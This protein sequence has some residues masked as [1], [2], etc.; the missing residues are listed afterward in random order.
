MNPPNFLPEV[1]SAGGG[2][3]ATIS[4]SNLGSGGKKTLFKC[5][6]AVAVHRLAS[7]IDALLPTFFIIDSPMK[8]ISERENRA[9]FEGFFEMLY[10]LSS[11]ELNGT[12]FIVIDKEVCLPPVGYALSF[13]ERRMQPNQKG[14]DPSTN[15]FPPLIRYY[16]G[17]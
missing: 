9:Q 1:S 2:D 14:T 4:F 6:F 17:K 5:C 11:T 12:Q 8:N 10:G 16:I 15:S 3:L 7:E 13:S